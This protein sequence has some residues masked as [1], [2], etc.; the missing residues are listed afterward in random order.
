MGRIASTTLPTLILGLRRDGFHGWLRLNRG[1]LRR[2]FQ[3]VAGRLARLESKAPEDALAPV[4]QELGSLDETECQRVSDAVAEGT[5]ELRAIAGLRKVAPKDLLAG[6]AEQARRAAR[7]SLGW[8]DGEFA[9]EPEA[10]EANVPASAF[11]VVPIVLEAAARRIEPHQVLELLGDKATWFP[12]ATPEPTDELPPHPIL[13]AFRADLNGATAP[14]HLLRGAAPNERAAA[15]LVLE[16]CGHLEWAEA[17]PAPPEA[18]E[19]EADEAPR[20]AVEDDAPE[21]ELEFASECSEES[22]ATE[23]ADAAVATGR[24]EK[25]EALI[26]EIR[27]LHER[28]GEVDH[29]T[30]LGVPADAKPAAIRR[31]YLKLAKRLHP[32]AVARMGIDEVREEANAVFAQIG[33]AHETL[34][35][36]DERER[37]DASLRGEDDIDLEKVAQAEALYQKA[38]MLMRAGNFLG[39]VEFLEPA[40]ELYAAEAD[41]Q[42]SLGWC[43]FKKTPP[44]AER[45]FQHLSEAIR[46]APK[47]AIWP[48]RLHYV[49]RELGDHV[50]SLES[51]AKARELDPSVG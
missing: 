4:L 43:L 10:G 40:V 31:A 1:G 17:P 5:P 39:A 35:D 28:L 11:D 34:S 9:L 50:G 46:M 22:V 20:E 51:L 18:A 44:E 6:V 7:D 32:D 33:E 26:E 15:L 3:F 8:Y 29:Y 37:Y 42:G 2:D 13:D 41:Y 49:Q 25:E 14:F 30:L 38:E 48:Y 12:S 24:T 21:L 45:A 19:D 27:G 47:V 23:A 16:S 36:A